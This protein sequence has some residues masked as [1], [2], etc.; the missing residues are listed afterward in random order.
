MSLLLN[1]TLY[2]TDVDA[3]NSYLE[4]Y[5]NQTLENSGMNVQFRLVHSE[6]IK[7]SAYQCVLDSGQFS[8][9]KRDSNVAAFR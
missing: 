2:G 9:L 6:D 1:I 4:N 3:R 8:E 5:V 7:D